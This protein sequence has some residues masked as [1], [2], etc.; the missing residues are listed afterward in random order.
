MKEDDTKGHILCNVT[1][2]NCPEDGDPFR[3]KAYWWLKN[4][5]QWRTD[6][7]GNGFLSDTG[8]TLGSKSSDSSTSKKVQK[9]LNS[10]LATGKCKI[11]VVHF[12][13]IK[14]LS[15]TTDTCNVILNEETVKC[16]TW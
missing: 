16:T 12:Y 11:S 1:H 14:D 9:S 13:P 5:D 2:K 15:H 10:P 4:G 8:K 6:G 3:E 7:I